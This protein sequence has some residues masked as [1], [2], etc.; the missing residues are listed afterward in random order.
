MTLGFGGRRGGELP[1]EVTELVGRTTELGKVR[2]LLDRA[3]LVTLTGPGGVGKSRIALRTAAEAKPDYADGV[4]LIELSELQDPELLPHTLAT[5]LGL[6]EQAAR[7]PLD[8]LVEYLQDRQVL[9]VL[10]TCEHLVDACAM[11]ADVLLR[12]A[13]RVT[14]LATSRQP[15]DVP[16]EHTLQIP[17]L[18]VQDAVTL[19]GRRAAAVVPGFAVTDANR[20]DVLVLCRRLDG[21]PLAIELATVRL[22]AI[23]LDQLTARLED[24]FRILGGGRRTSLPRHQTLRTAIGWSHELCSPEE[25]LL[26]ARLSVFA[27][28]FD[29]AAVEQVC[30]GG[31]LPPAAVLEHLIALVDKSVV[32][33]VDDTTGG[34]G[35]T[36]YRLLDTIREYGAEWL[37]QTDGVLA[38][39]RRHRDHHLLLAERFYDRLLTDDQVPL[40]QALVRDQANIRAALEYSFAEPQ[41]LLHGLVLASKLW[42]YWLTAGLPTEG[43]Y[44]LDKGLSLSPE[45]GPERA[46]ALVVS[47]MLALMQGDLGAALTRFEEARRTAEQ[48]GDPTALAYA[49]GYV[50]GVHGLYGEAER[51]RELTDDA[52]ARLRALDDRLGLVMSHYQEGFLRAVI[53]DIPG[54][55][56][57]CDLALAYLGEQ[58]ADECMIQSNIMLIK[59]IVAWDAG[60]RPECARLIRAAL[61][62]KRELGEVWGLA[63]CTEALAWVA[64][65]ERRYARTAWMLGAAHTLWRR[66]GTPMFG[67]ETLLQQH[68]RSEGAAR[69]ALG[70][71]VYERLFERGARLPLDRA[72]ELV[73]ADADSPLR[74]PAPDSERRGGADGLTPRERE[75]A[76][77]VAQGLSNRE[78]AERLV[79][80]KRTAD[81]HVEHILAKLG[82]SSRTEIAALAGEV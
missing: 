57:M 7:A 11:L 62:K 18:P 80:S 22:R 71:Q 51:S 29:L 53:D 50:G 19:F 33:R 77:L 9:I 12:E 25:R 4:C 3:R 65:Q 17:P 10:D 31:D 30:S 20:A 5:F 43:R 41:G 45:P 82:A 24:R 13:P 34:K 59:G 36:R 73:L 70:A 44:W 74:M 81:A 38:C 72:V 16:G 39:R 27:G 14:V 66:I 78:I 60:D 54:A 64:A 47:G 28:T 69:E 68:A 58:A 46:H 42:A 23:P 26:W 48:V 2:R 6:P 56:E 67:V 49:I 55:I 35:S 40:Y 8:L 21:I 61:L 63:H 37:A 76:A 32:L 1:V 75:V 52:R 15:L 79:I